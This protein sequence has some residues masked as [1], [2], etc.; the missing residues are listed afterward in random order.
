[1]SVTEWLRRRFA[2]VARDSR[3]GLNFTISGPLIIRLLVG[4]G[5]RLT[6]LGP[7]LG[8]LG[9]YQTLISSLLHKYAAGRLKEI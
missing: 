1:V 4:V 3:T 6:V 7:S 9:P 8:T 5:C 2:K